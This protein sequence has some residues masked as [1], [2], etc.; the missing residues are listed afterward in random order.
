MWGQVK[1]RLRDVIWRWRGVLIV[2]PSVTAV[3]V[4]MRS[5]GLLQ[6]LELQVL[7]QFFILQ[8]REKVDSRI[9]IVEI[10]EPDVQA[11]VRRDGRW[12]MSDKTLAT[13]IQTIKKQQPSVIGLDIYRDLPQ[14]PGHETLVKVFET[15]PN[16]VGVQKVISSPDS[17]AVA[18]SPILKKLDQVGANDF[19]ID[20]DGKIRRIPLYLS[21][22]QG[23]NIFG[24]GF[25]LAALDLQK[26]GIKPEISSNN[27][28]QLGSVVFPFFEK[29]NGGYVN[30]SDAG[31]QAIL[32]YRGNNFQ[33]ITLSDVLNNRIPP[34]LLRDRIVL[35]GAAAESLKDLFFTPYSSTLSTPV[36]MAGVEIHANLTSQ[37]L[38]AVLDGRAPTLKTSNETEEILWIFGWAAAG[39][40]L[41]WNQRSNASNRSISTTLRILLA[42]VC[43]VGISY[44]A[45]LQSWWIPVIPSL[46][47][48][49]G[50]AIAITSYI[51]R[52]ATKIREVFGRYVTDEVVA[53]LLETPAGLNLGGERR[54]VTILM[55][56]L[57]GF[58]SI[59]EKL[60]PEK[61]VE[62]LNI[63]LAE[64]TEVI[65]KYKGTIDEFI[66]DA[67]LAIFGAPV[68]SQDDAQRAVA[69]AIEMQLSMEK[70]NA[71]LA[72]KNLPTVAMG[73]GI[74]TGEVVVGNIGSQV[75]AK[76][77]IVGNHV[78]LASRIESYTIGRQILI[79][80]YT[81]YEASNLLKIDNQFQVE[82]KGIKEPINIYEV[83]GIAGD[84]D[85]FLPQKLE[86][87]VSLNSPISLRYAVLEGKDSSGSRFEG[88]IVK[89]SNQGAILHSENILARFS[90]L[91]INFLVSEQ[92]DLDNFDLYAKV[93]KIPTDHSGGYHI[94]FSNVPPELMTFIDQLRQFYEPGIPVSIME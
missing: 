79:S 73:I 8:P 66:G 92:P 35:I 12:P 89:L 29:N 62:I 72:L 19:V 69:C 42:A 18:P 94:Y 84:F 91:K 32:K 9:V 44:A 65:Q 51:A 36:R 11:V 15:T 93:L 3:V 64:M 74:N 55:C 21:D 6:N 81:Y 82:P 77:G 39:A 90:N 47:A 86:D 4:G 2:I 53:S 60:S 30:A 14:N 34:G 80:E 17:S 67:V 22:Q 61:V 16:L 38:S 75:R 56:D 63:F 46:M 57:R 10:T 76:Y 27:L 25:T 5:L 48:L 71:Q 85:L 45:F 43:L 40:I 68:L 49:L 50:S 26:R 87:F 13:V 78:N 54:K 20:P 88:S 41:S 23:N 59:S 28:I 52:S 31:Y 33:K 7:D 70:V 58:S 37:I 1:D 24:F 83:S